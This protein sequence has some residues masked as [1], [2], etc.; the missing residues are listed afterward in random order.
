MPEEAIKALLRRFPHRDVVVINFVRAPE[1]MRH[2]VCVLT[3]GG[4]C[5]RAAGD[6]QLAAF[7]ALQRVLASES[8]GVCTVS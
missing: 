6:S 3:H 1:N 8:G 4:D 5:K 7:E 2:V